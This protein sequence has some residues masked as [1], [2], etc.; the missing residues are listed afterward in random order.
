MS[1]LVYTCVFDN[2][3]WVLPP[4][5]ARP[6]IRHILVTDQDG[7]APAG[8]ER[9]VVDPAEHGS[10]SAANRYWK[11]LG[12]RELPS[13]ERTLYVDANIRLLGDSASFLDKVLPE[14]SAMGL[15]R[16][17]LRKTIADEARAC[18]QAGKVEKPETLYAELES[19]GGMGFHDDQGL[20]E[21][22]IL[23][24][25]TNAP[26]L[27]A[28]M[29]FWWELYLRQSGRDQISLPVVRWRTALDVSWIDW[30]FRDPNPWFA[31]YSHRKARGVNPLYAF[32]E[33]RSHDSY[34]HTA[35]LR[36]WRAFR[37][38]RRSLRAW[39]ATRFAS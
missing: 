38:L 32:V 1:D 15:F 6:G 4:I 22:G 28:A 3:D 17:P 21:N 31:T 11:M 37:T 30:S 12:W 10:S 16:H 18:I 25:R 26:G 34:A 9:R 8:W 7:P 23:A 24:R 29:Q 39:N 19:Y 5:A 35:M 2:Y 20:S 13:C 36:G 14:S 33:A 27:D